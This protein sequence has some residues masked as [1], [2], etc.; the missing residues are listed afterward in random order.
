[1]RKIR[2]VLAKSDDDRSSHSNHS[3][4][5][6]GY[7]TLKDTHMPRILVEDGLDILC[8]PQGILRSLTSVDAWN[9]H[10]T[11]HLLK[12]YLKAGIKNRDK[13][14]RLLSWSLRDC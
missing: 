14:D 13:G 12:P 8:G 6:N 11:T 2:E 7:G 1:M 5:C 10:V 9:F 3:F 4:H